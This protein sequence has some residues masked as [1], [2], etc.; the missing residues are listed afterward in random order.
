M[1]EE[2]FREDAYARSCTTRVVAAG[3][4]GVVL[5]R[6]V[7]YPRAGGQPGDQGRLMLGKDG[8]LVVNDT[9]RDPGT[10]RILHVLQG[11]DL[12]DA[13]ASVTAE[14]DWVRRYRLM[15]VHSC[16]HL[17][18]RAVDAPVTGG[19]IDDGKGRLDFDLGDTVPDRESLTDRLNRWIEADLPIR[20]YWISD[21]ELAA[22]PELV[23]T[24]SVRPPAGQGRVRLVE[25]AGVDLQACGGTHVRSTGEIGRVAVGKMESKGKRN[26]RI[27]IALVETM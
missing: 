17:L 14:I 7:F 25:I 10:G 15:R 26:R 20:A 24:M 6:T 18:C 3:P 23:R 4:D 11:T 22:R 8:T 13:G 12:P 1:T 27:G 16:L 19:Q 9:R 2:L 21:E 5:D